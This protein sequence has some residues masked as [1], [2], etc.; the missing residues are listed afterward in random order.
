MSHQ[1]PPHSAA[2]LLWRGD[3]M[4][5]Y[6]QAGLLS[7]LDTTH[8][9]LRPGP[10]HWWLVVRCHTSKHDERR[11]TMLYLLIHLDQQAVSLQAIL[12][13]GIHSQLD[14]SHC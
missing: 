10:Q 2:L 6:G 14:T 5:E 4:A 8:C 7:H 1:Y 11:Q 9:R 13:S 12:V 3:G